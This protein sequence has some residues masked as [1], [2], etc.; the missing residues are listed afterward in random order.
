ME[1]LLPF[2]SPCTSLPSSKLPSDIQTVLRL[3]LH[4]AHSEHIFHAPTDMSDTGATAPTGA[5]ESR[6][7]GETDLLSSDSGTDR[8]TSSYRH[9]LRRLFYQ[10]FEYCLGTWDPVQACHLGPLLAEAP[11]YS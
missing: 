5:G 6:R 9:S 11:T 8:K 10:D 1:C 2:S 7:R 4:S 3:E